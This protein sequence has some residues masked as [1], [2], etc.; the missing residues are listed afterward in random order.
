ME[1]E[2]R[3]KKKRKRQLTLLKQEEIQS[4]SFPALMEVLEELGKEGKFVD[5]Q[6]CPR[7]KSA[8]VRRVGSMGGDMS[9]HMAVT[10]V[11]YECL[12]CGWRERLVIKA[13]NR[14]LGWREV[15]IIAEALDLKDKK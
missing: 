14:P 5:V 1:E 6:I 8:K 3:K 13:T 11:K 15:A 7:C 12:D 4:G 2:Q 10:P 9:G